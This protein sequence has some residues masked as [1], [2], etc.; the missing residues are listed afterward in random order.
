M[1]LRQ[2]GL[3][4]RSQRKKCGLRQNDLAG[5]LDVTPQAVSKWER[6]ENA[7]DIGLLVPLA[8][9]LLV[10]V[11]WLLGSYSDRH[12]VFEA[13]VFACAV[14]GARKRSETMELREL[15]A[16]TN[17][18]CFQL[19]E[20]FLRHYG[21]LVKHM[22]PGLLCFFSGSRHKSR[23]LQAALEAAGISEVPLKIGISTGLIYF[24]SVG[25]PD[26]AR[27]D[28][29]GDAVRI[30]VLTADWAGGNTK[31]GIAACADTVRGLA[32][33]FSLGTERT[34]KLAGITHPVRLHE[35]RKTSQAGRGRRP[36]A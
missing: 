15:A 36:N 8:K 26:Y 33:D 7:P 35:V 16:W 5:A 31:S 3:R 20:T 11:D 34:V 17:G 19:T 29:L 32:E 6:G 14:P 30:A 22:N 23:A 27:P 2:L 4:I 25:H 12:D 9:L 13:T 24:G 28:I 18:V 10:S 21:V 1:D